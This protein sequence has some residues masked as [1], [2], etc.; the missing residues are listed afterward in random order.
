MRYRIAWREDKRRRQ[1]LDNTKQTGDNC[2]RNLQIMGLIQH[3][4]SWSDEG[5]EGMERNTKIRVLYE[6]RTRWLWEQCG[7]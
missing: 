6:D 5:K 1:R 2:V 4:I 7:D 3:R